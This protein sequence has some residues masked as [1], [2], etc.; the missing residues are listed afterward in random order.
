[1]GAGGILDSMRSSNSRRVFWSRIPYSTC[2]WFL[3]HFPHTGS[4][5]IS[6]IASHTLCVWRLIITCQIWIVIINNNCILFLSDLANLLIVKN[7]NVSCLKK[8]LYWWLRIPHVFELIG[9]KIHLKCFVVHRR[10]P[11]FVQIC[12]LCFSNSIPFEHLFS[13]KLLSSSRI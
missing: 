2:M 1:M 10:M 3:Q 11:V 7:F 13:F 4:R 5:L 12:S 6:H 9:L 8:L